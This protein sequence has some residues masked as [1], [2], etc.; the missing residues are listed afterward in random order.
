[1]DAAIVGSADYIVTNDQH[2]KVLV[3]IDF[4]KVRTINIEGFLQL[5][6][7]K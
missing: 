1:V 3:S 2:F 6:L 5:I 4:P 7:N